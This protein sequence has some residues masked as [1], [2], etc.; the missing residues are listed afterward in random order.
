MRKPSGAGLS[1]CGLF[2]ASEISVP[3][4]VFQILEKFVT[5]AD[6]L[7]K[8]KVC[9]NGAKPTK[10]SKTFDAFRGCRPHTFIQIAIQNITK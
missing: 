5:A 1:H 10:H 6:F 4:A 2:I 9:R 3:A 8:I 7:K